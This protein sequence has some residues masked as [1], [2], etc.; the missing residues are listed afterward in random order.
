MKEEKRRRLFIVR[1]ILN[2]LFM[3]I[4]VVGLVWYFAADRGTGLIIIICSI[5]LKM[6]STVLR[7]LKP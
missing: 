1:N 6:T 3:I 5:P 7:L 4:A 2:L